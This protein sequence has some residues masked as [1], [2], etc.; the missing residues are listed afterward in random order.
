MR[1]RV[2]SFIS[3]FAL[4]E[5][6]F[7]YGCC[8]WFAVILCKRFEFET[9]G[10]CHIYYHPVDNHFAAMIDGTLYDVTGSISPIGFEPWEQYM[11]YDVELYTRILNDCILFPPETHK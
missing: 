3:H 11:Q 7:L 1:Q 9:P 5:D 6:C 8:Y 4:G 10:N 2:L